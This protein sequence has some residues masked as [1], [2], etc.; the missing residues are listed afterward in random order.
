MLQRYEYKFR[1][2]K[3]SR[4]SK[5]SEEKPK[6]KPLS[7]DWQK[8]VR[9]LFKSSIYLFREMQTIKNMLNVLQAY[10]IFS[11]VTLIIEWNSDEQDSVYDF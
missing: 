6:G 1:P 10:E 7:S 3:Q 4:G 9:F 2:N 8:I 5:K 11:M